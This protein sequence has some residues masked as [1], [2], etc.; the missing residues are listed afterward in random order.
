M[1]ACRLIV[2]NYNRKD[3]LERFLPSVIRSAQASH[4]PCSVTVLDNGSVD[5]SAEFVRKKF[6]QADFFSASAN[7]VLCSY[8]EIAPQ[9][10]EDILIFLNNDIETDIDFVD[11]LM[12]AFETREDVFFVSTHGDCSIPVIQWG[13]IRPSLTDSGAA[14]RIEVPGWSFSAGVGAFDRRKFLQIGGYDELYLPGYYEDVD[15]CF[16]A[17]KHGWKGIYEP[18]SQKKHLGAASFKQKY[19]EAFIQR[20]A[21]RN[22]LLFMVKNISDPGLYLQFILFLVLRLLTAWARGQGFVYAG[23]RDALPRIPAALQSRKKN[24]RLFHVTDREVLQMFKTAKPAKLSIRFLRNLVDTCFLNPLGRALF[25]VLGFFTVR[26]IYPLQYL[27]LR[28]LSSMQS[29]LD[30]GCG[31]HSMVPII[32][33][34][35]N[36]TGVELF[37]ASY[38][39]AVE[40]GRHDRYLRDDLTKVQFE[41]KSFDAAVMLDVLEHLNKEDGSALLE[42]MEKWAKRRVVIF[43]PNGFHHQECYDD[44]PLMEHKSGWTV[45]DFRKR[46]Y[47]VY[48]VRGF[49]ALKEDHGHEATVETLKDRLVDLTQIFTYHFPSTAFQLYCVKDLGGQ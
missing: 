14:K 11:P 22:G 36:S 26:L 46:G 38:R 21:F 41:P 31:S 19:G 8:N 45:E 42:R 9:C 43:T 18:G 2:L 28:D 40:S 1:K 17:W 37:E 39:K 32:P 20:T 6:P 35:I 10:T 25:S 47:R 13:M 16:R 29:V 44:N 3:L 49:K 12:Q 7:K 34:T 15:L 4:F 23:F 24:K 27:V 5:G 48:G 30:L 33:S